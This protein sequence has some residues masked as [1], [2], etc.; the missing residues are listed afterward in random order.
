MADYVSA[1]KHGARTASGER[2]NNHGLTAAHR[3]YALG[4]RV[5]VTNLKNGRSV[6]V[7]INDRGLHRRGYVIR[8]TRLAAEQLKFTSTGSARVRVEALD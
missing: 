7:R 2:F 4:S 8:V 6:V 1:A 5:R 3:T